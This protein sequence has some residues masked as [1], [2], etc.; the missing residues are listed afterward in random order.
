MPPAAVRGS[1]RG[2]ARTPA[3]ATLHALAAVA[4]VFAVAAAG[5]VSCATAAIP[6]R[7]AAESPPPRHTFTRGVMGGSGRITI[8]SD[9]EAAARAAAAAA[10]ARLDEIEAALSDYRSDSEIARL[11][12]EPFRWHTASGT[13]AA[14]VRAAKALSEASGGRFDPT[15]GPLSRL[16]RDA[17]RSGVLPSDEAIAEARA[18][19]GWHLLELRQSDRGLEIKFLAAGMGLDFGGIGKGLAADE[20]LAVLRSLGMAAAIVDLGGDIAVGAAP[21]GSRGWR[22]A[23]VG[24]PA[25]S[26]S[27]SCDEALPPMLELAECG[28]ATSGDQ[29]QHLAIG[30]DRLSHLLDPASG[31]PANHAPTVTVVARNAAAADGLATAIS[32]L[33]AS[34]A[35]AAAERLGA[36]AR[37]RTADGQVWHAGSL[38]ANRNAA[39][40]DP[41]P[42]SPSR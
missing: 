42:C 29:Q 15:L 26:S 32:L 1:R 25:G 18:R 20:A 24:S 16:W 41:P 35:A 19:C 5:G 17:R 23:L 40:S 38:P 27:G 10:F 12:R 14:A 33:D 34:Q 3:L 39:A 13:L 4:S 11:A 21:R 30:G 37:V 36:W 8:C 6:G 31:S 28:I 7:E 22:V 9:D 2:A